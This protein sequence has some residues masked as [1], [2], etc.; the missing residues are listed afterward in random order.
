MA[1][2]SGIERPLNRETTIA[3]ITSLRS[4]ATAVPVALTRSS[5]AAAAT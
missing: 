5:F 4:A 1:Q 2:S 3:V